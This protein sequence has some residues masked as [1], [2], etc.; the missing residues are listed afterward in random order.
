MG[1]DGARN[2]ELLLVSAGSLCVR[3]HACAFVCVCI[4]KGQIVNQIPLSSGGVTRSTR[5]PPL[6]EKRLHFE[7]RKVLETTNILS[8][9]LKGPETRFDCA[10]EAISNL[11]NPLNFNG[12]FPM[13][14]TKPKIKYLEYTC[15]CIRNW[16]KSRYFHSVYFWEG[17]IETI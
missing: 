9:V 8:W 3:V 5:I 14:H 17:C 4:G 7:T 11:P 15:I 1:L 12:S 2:P 10:G 6:I 13:R 16:R